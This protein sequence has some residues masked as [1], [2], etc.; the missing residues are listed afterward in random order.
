MTRTE[1][2]QIEDYKYHLPDERIAKYPLEQ[3][4]QS[5]L[6]H[7]HGGEIQEYGFRSLPEL[8]PKGALMIFN[9]TKVMLFIS[10]HLLLEITLHK[11]VQKIVKTQLLALTMLNWLTQ[12]YLIITYQIISNLSS[13][14]KQCIKVVSNSI[15]TLVV[16]KTEK[17]LRY[18][19]TQ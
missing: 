15:I 9:N 16:L 6:L 5:K 7:Y 10:I 19:D 12:S 8:L 13:T 17:M 4:D 3:R 1:Q 11:K 2:I 14:K 18:L